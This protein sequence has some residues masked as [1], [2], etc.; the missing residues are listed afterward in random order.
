M[1]VTQRRPRD[2]RGGCRVDE[3]QHVVVQDTRAFERRAEPALE[4]RCPPWRRPRRSRW[5]DRR[6]QAERDRRQRRAPSAPTTPAAVPSSDIAPDVPGGT[7]LSDVIDH[8]GGPTPCRFRSRSYRCRRPPARRRTPAAPASADGVSSARSARDRRDAGVRD[9]VA[10]AAASAALFGDAEQHLALAAR[11]AMRPTRRRTSASSSIQP[12]QPSDREDDRADERA[13][14]RAR[15]SR[16]FARGIRRTATSAF[17]RSAAGQHASAIGH[18]RQSDGAFRRS[19]TPAT[20]WRPRSAATERLSSRR[21]GMVS[22]SGRRH[23]RGKREADE[24]RPRALEAVAAGRHHQARNTAAAVPPATNASDPATV[25]SRFH[26]HRA[27]AD[28]A[29]DERRDAVADRQDAPRAPRRCRAGA[30]SRAAA[31][32]PTADRRG[33]RAGARA[34]VAGAIEAA[35]HA[36]QHEEIEERARRRR[37]RPPATT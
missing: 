29:S 4:Q 17:A 28:R 32:A 8:V 19:A 30:G 35:G 23:R 20:A 13:G 12:R 9:R 36:R 2:A 21:T 18:P 3:V 10:R 37:A 22:T 33:C 5:R 16:R 24:R 31:S 27:P 7:R 26:G 14:D 25:F 6:H 34:V 11:A 1:T 15:T